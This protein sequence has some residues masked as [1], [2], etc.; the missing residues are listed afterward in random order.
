MK[1]II[2]IFLICFVFVGGA[3]FFGYWSMNQFNRYFDGLSTSLA[4]VNSAHRSFSRPSRPNEEI[5]LTT[6]DIFVG[7]ATSTDPGSSSSTST[8][9]KLSL[10]FPENNTEVYIGCTYPISWHSSTTVNS[11]EVALI[12]VDTG[13][14]SGPIASGLAEEYEIKTDS[15]SLD[16]EVGVVWPG[17]YFILISKINGVEE[18]IKSKYF[19]INKMPEDISDNERENICKK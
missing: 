2:R 17:E 7:S 4:N 10:T 15:Q 8:V 5:A 16:W 18:E 1:N 12:D 3:A 6:L 14:T 19:M 13:E 11:L 9:S